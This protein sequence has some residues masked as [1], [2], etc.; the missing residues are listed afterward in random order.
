M[1]VNLDTICGSVNYI[2]ISLEVIRP[3]RRVVRTGN[4]KL[5]SRSWSISH[6]TSLIAIAEC[7]HVCGNL[8]YKFDRK[9]RIRVAEIFM[10]R[11]PEITP[12][13]EHNKRTYERSV[14]TDTKKKKK[15]PSNS[16]RFFWAIF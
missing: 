3:Q 11:A 4:C 7:F 5:C 16:F 2:K 6:K 14:A 8:R 15:V 12:E 13:D 9:L 1:P 10:E